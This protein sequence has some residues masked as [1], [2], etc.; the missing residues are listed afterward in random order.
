M[1]LHGNGF[2]DELLAMKKETWEG[3]P[4]TEMSEGFCFQ[5]NP[6]LVL[7]CPSSF[8]IPEQGQPLFTS[9]FNEASYPFNE[10][11]LVCE[12]EASYKK[13]AAN[14]LLP[15]QDDCISSI[16][17]EE[18]GLL[19]ENIYNSENHKIGDIE[20]VPSPKIPALDV[21]GRK[22]KAKRLE[23]QPSKNL[24]AERR[25]RKRLNDRLSMLRSVVPKISKVNP[26]LFNL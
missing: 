21:V 20:M 12:M 6:G 23:G 18:L 11:L 16:D 14:L 2:L 19:F 5:E 10:G 26:K 17:D 25:R 4:P 15:S 24:M 1:E 7:P 8:G 9:A 22:N 3:L 13:T